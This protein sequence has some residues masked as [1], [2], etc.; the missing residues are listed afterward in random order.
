MGSYVQ[1]LSQGHHQFGGSQADSDLPTTVLS[2]HYTGTRT[3]CQK[4][5]QRAT[6]AGKERVVINCCKDTASELQGP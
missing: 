4:A 2:L 5:R 3:G 6:G 1:S